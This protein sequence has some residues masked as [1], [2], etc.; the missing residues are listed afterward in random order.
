MRICTF[1]YFAAGIAVVV[2]SVLLLL[3]WASSDWGRNRLR[4]TAGTALSIGGLM[5]LAGYHM[6]GRLCG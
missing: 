4:T 6:S 3:E 1:V 2:G 5:Y